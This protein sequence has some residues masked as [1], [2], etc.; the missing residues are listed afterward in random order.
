MRSLRKNIFADLP[1]KLTEELLE[2]LI[3]S[4]CVR[5]ERIVS[6]GQTTPP[7][8][9]YDQDRDEWVLVLQGRALLSCDGMSDPIALAAGDY[10][11]IPAHCRHRVEWTDPD[12][13]TVWLAIHW[14]P[15]KLLT[16]SRL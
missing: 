14:Q 1:A 8:R 11:L 16:R 5:I 15:N 10:Y 3:D 12:D 4:E 2:T 13:H 9:Y 7:G 6:Q